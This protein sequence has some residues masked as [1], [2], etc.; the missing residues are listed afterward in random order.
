VGYSFRD[1]HIN[2]LIKRWISNVENYDNGLLIVDY[3]DTDEG[4]TEFKKYVKKQ[5]HLKSAIPDECFVFDGVNSIKDICG[6][7]RDRTKIRKSKKQ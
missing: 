2:E 1:E 3:K 6:T 4:K 5:L 7:N